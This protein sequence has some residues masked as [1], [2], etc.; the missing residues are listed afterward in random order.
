MESASEILWCAKPD[1]PELPMALT[2]FAQEYDQLTPGEQAQFAEAVR[3]LLADGLIWREDENDRRI[4][5]FLSRRRELVA[6]YLQVAGWE[7]RFEERLNIFH[8]VHRE[9]AHR[10]RLNRDTTIW[11]LLL[12]LIYA[13]KRESMSI[14]LTRYPVVA[15]GEVAG[16]YAAFFPGQVVRKKTS[17][18][19]ALR[20]LQALKLIRAAGGGSLHA[21]NGEQLIELLPA[22]EV[23]VPAADISAVVDQLS[24]YNRSTAGEGLAE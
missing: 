24:P 4:Y 14:Q 5:A 11:L 23:V 21:G 22:L 12:R 19:E 2:Q 3:R 16:R 18:E 17:L 8:V 15:V 20:T 9:H 13:E 10:R 6:D 7:L 1:G